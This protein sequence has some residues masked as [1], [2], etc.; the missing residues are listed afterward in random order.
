MHGNDR[1]NRNKGSIRRSYKLRQRISRTLGRKCKMVND[2][3]RLWKF[4]LFSALTGGIYSFYF[5]Y[6]MAQ[7][8]NV[9][10]EGDGKQTAGLAKYLLFSICTLGIY[11]FVWH[12]KL[13]NRMEE[14]ASRYDTY[15]S[16]TGT[17]VMLWAIPGMLLFGIG[18][19]VSYY[20]IIKNM[21]TLA[22]GYLRTKYAELPE[23]EIETVRHAS[24]SSRS[25]GKWVPVLLICVALLVVGYASYYF[26]WLPLGKDLSVCVGKKISTVKWMHPVKTW[27]PIHYQIGDQALI[28]N[29]KTKMVMGVRNEDKIDK[30]TTHYNVK[31]IYRKQAQDKAKH[32]INKYYFAAGTLG[33]VSKR[34]PDYF[35][36]V[37]YSG[38]KVE[39]VVFQYWDKESREQEWIENAQ[40]AAADGDYVKASE[41]YE[42]VRYK[43]VKAQLEE[44]WYNQGKKLYGEGAY[45]DA[46]TYFSKLKTDTYAQE[47]EKY[48]MLFREIKNIFSL[49]KDKTHHRDEWYTNDATGEEAH[50]VFAEADMEKR[51][52]DQNSYAVI[53]WSG[54]GNFDTL[55]ESGTYQLKLKRLS[56]Q[57]I[58]DATL[59]INGDHISNQMAI[60]NDPKTFTVSNLEIVTGRDIMNVIFQ[61]EIRNLCKN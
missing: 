22:S 37:E 3:R 55:E 29:P 19:L 9:I 2:N 1:M 30:K 27:T 34:N 38:K 48:S 10:C 11:A 53:T 5:I 52:N 31:G 43:N 8:I 23:S 32:Q 20:I 25:I 46:E 21:N 13:A 59:K 42:A 35:L 41:Y 6:K 14:N 40:E 51:K 49:D 33:Y 50:L 44:C 16:E 7:D 60:G 54:K 26:A 56:D 17:T 47:K 18:P 57:Q 45:L 39:H 28:V 15:I 58:C 36:T 61:G 4:I 12:Y 24:V